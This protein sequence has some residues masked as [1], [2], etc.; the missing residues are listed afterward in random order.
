MGSKVFTLNVFGHIIIENQGYILDV[1]TTTSHVSSDKNVLGPTLQTL[2]SILTLLLS[3]A[4]VK[5]ASAV[6]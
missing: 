4:S 1:N 3:F 2:E 6:L 5:C